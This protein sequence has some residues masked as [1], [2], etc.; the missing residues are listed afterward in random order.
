MA[1]NSNPHSFSNRFSICYTIKTSYFSD[2]DI[3][4]IKVIHY[5]LPGSVRGK[6]HCS[7][8]MEPGS[9]FYRRQTNHGSTCQIVVDQTLS[10][11]NPI[12]IDCKVI[13]NS[14]KALLLYRYLLFESIMYINNELKK[15]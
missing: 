14:D 11:S 9:I 8:Y 2:D 12:Q 15:G 7:I 1:L 5:L 4:F 10:S 6:C 3:W 13:R